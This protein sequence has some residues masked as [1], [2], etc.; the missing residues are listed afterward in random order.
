[1]AS[2]GLKATAFLLAAMAALPAC[3][4][5]PRPLA[6]DPSLPAPAEA[7]APTS[8]APTTTAPPAPAPTTT[9]PP[10]PTRAVVEAPWTPMATVGPITLVHPSRRVERVGFHESNHD[11]AQHLAPLATAAAPTTLEARERGTGARTAADVVVDP[12][13]EIRSPVTGRV[14]RSGGYVLYCKHSDDYVVIAPDA[15]PTWEVKVLHIDGVRVK[16]GDRV[17]AGVTVLAPR[18]TQLPFESQVDELRTADPAWPHV[19]IEVVDPAIKDRPT[20]GGGCP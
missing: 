4:S 5:K 14:K 6:V 13:V 1:M 18:A 3:A 17:V 12:A 20:P 2:V 8:A 19:H 9:A 16:A 10:A 7:T 11:G 15:Q